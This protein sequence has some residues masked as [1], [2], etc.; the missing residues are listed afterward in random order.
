MKATEPIV[1][2]TIIIIVFA[3]NSKV[4]KNESKQE[5]KTRCRPSKGRRCIRDVVK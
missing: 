3:A 1:N 2:P 5:R 4:L